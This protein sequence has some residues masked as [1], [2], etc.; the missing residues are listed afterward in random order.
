MC[1][2]KNDRTLLM[3]CTVRYDDSELS[4]RICKGDIF[5][6]TMNEYVRRYKIPLLYIGK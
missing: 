4:T 6:C 2:G 3:K 5:A 1:W